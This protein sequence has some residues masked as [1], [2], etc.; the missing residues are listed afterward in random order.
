MSPD[1]VYAQCHHEMVRVSCIFQWCSYYIVICDGGTWSIR[2][3]LQFEGLRGKCMPECFKSL[4][5]CWFV[6]VSIIRRIFCP[7][8]CS[9]TCQNGMCNWQLISGASI[10]VS[11]LY[12]ILMGII[13]FLSVTMIE[14]VWA[15]YFSFI[16]FSTLVISSRKPKRKRVIYNEDL[17][18]HVR[19][20]NGDSILWW[21]LELVLNN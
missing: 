16:K 17:R 6:V 2:T 21:L 8:L 20:V 14:I 7:N 1:A 11:R 12:I 15:Y 18:I 19:I 10:D 9:S 13:E 4:N 3:S 5:L